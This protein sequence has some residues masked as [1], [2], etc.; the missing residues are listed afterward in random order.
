MKR[1]Y[2]RV[3]E[4]GAFLCEGA[5]M[6]HDN[7]LPE[8]GERSLGFPWMPTGDFKPGMLEFP[9][10]KKDNDGYRIDQR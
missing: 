9:T 10:D 3:Y 4:D 8:V 7:C 5:R 1:K 2:L 6:L